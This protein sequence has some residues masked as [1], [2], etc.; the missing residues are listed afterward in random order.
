MNNVE[1]WGMEIC[2][3][4]RKKGTVEDDKGLFERVVQY[5]YDNQEDIDSSQSN[6]M[7]AEDIL[8][9][10]IFTPFVEA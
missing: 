4:I 9:Y 1:E 6:E 7:V 8:S 5:L 3:I 2:E 10:E